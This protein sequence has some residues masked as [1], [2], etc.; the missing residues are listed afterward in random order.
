MELLEEHIG[1]NLYDLGLGKAFL[2]MTSK[3]NATKEKR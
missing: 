2:E 1:I 3:A